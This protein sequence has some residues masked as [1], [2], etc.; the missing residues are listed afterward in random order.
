L[1]LRKGFFDFKL[2]NKVHRHYVQS[3]LGAN[4]MKPGKTAP[5][6]SAKTRGFTLVELLVVI[7]IIGI[8]IALLLPAIQ[9]AREAARRMQCRNNL[10][11]IG[12]ACQTHVDRQKHYPAGGWGW[13]WVGDP[14]DGYAG[15]QPGGWIYNILPGLELQALRD[16]GKGLSQTIQNN[17]NTTMIQTP[18]QVMTCPSLHPM[19]LMKAT[20]WDYHN[21]T[22]PGAT[23]W[24]VA[25]CDYAAC[26]SSGNSD[27]KA[28]T[29]GG[30]TTDP[31][32]GFPWKEVWNPAYARYMNGIIYQRSTIATKDVTRGTAHT[33]MVGEKYV[34]PDTYEAGTGSADNECMYVGQD[35]DVCRIT[36]SPPVQDRKGQSSDIWFGSIHATGAHFVFA[37][38]GVHTITYDVDANA[39]KTAGARKVTKGYENAL[40][41]TSSQPVFT[42]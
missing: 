27:N 18:L 16:K 33:I 2:R 40:T 10:K 20:S 29:D 13:D 7:A 36:S 42:D 21:A 37:D 32:V 11:Q 31:A 9:A 15:K 41:P 6:V 38:G 34:N 30:P 28:E 19:K 14:D 12:E 22:N 5:S 35:N 17:I 3:Y 1:L 39:F 25:R 23:N 8:L 4:I 26:C 24:L